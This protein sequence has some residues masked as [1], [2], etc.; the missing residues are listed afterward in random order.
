MPS[1][2]E[3]WFAR[4]Y[5]KGVRKKTFLMKKELDDFMVEYVKKMKKVDPNYTKSK[6]VQEAVCEKL[7]VDLNDVEQEVDA[8]QRSFL[9][10]LILYETFEH[11][12]IRGLPY[13][14][15]V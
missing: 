8:R 1:R 6:L 5:E 13:G 4:A 14:R 2:Q 3:R 12:R 10:N 15:N 11:L 7:K 9:L